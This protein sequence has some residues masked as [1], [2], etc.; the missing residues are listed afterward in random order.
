MPGVGFEPTIP[1]LER[2]NTFHVLDQAATVIGVIIIIV[3]IR[4]RGHS[5]QYI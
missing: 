5:D 4:P 1:V 3:V 2:M